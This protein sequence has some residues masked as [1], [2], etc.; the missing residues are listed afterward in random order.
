MN[1]VETIKVILTLT[2]AYPNSYKDM[3]PDRIG[4]TLELWEELFEKDDGEIVL[5]SVKKLITELKFPP[6]IA[7]IKEE[8]KPKLFYPEE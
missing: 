8:I 6:T 4:Q 7:E 5:A 1:S 2:T 3:T